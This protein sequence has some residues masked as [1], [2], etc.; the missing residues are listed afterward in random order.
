[1][2]KKWFQGNIPVKLLSEQRKAEQFLS[3]NIETENT[4][5]KNVVL[6]FFSD[7][8]SDYIKGCEILQ[9]PLRDKLLNAQTE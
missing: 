5:V 8:H 4:A 1:M 9:Q 2:K 7:Q 3:D 6:K